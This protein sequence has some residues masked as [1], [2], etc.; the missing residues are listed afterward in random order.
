MAKFR[1]DKGELLLDTDALLMTVCALL[2]KT[3][4]F[5]KM[6]N[7]PYMKPVLEMYE[8]RCAEKVRAWAK[9]KRR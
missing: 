5:E 7:D 3:G 6:K 2:G 1:S 8:K 9:S 4:D